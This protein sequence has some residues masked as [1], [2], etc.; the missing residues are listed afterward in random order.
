MKPL[1]TLP[2]GFPSSHL[3][4]HSHQDVVLDLAI[5]LSQFEHCVVGVARVGQV[6]QVDH[7]AELWLWGLSLLVRFTLRFL[8]LKEKASF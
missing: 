1:Q 4:F 8:K 7:T 2:Q 5:G 6:A 3:A